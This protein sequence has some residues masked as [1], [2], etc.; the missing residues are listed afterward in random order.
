MSP[1]FCVYC[2]TSRWARPPQTRP[3]PTSPHAHKPIR[4]VALR[5]ILHRSQ[6]TRVKRIEQIE[7]Q[8]NLC[9][10]SGCSS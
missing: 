6:I 3:K 1:G 5:G 4:P 7:R 8:K 9:L 2:L 10:F